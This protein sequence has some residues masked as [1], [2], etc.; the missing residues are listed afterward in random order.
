MICSKFLQIS[1]LIQ[2]WHG[3]SK[4][5]KS[6]FV[7][8]IEMIICSELTIYFKML[9]KGCWGEHDIKYVKN[10]CFLWW[11]FLSV[12]LTLIEY[13]QAVLLFKVNYTNI[14]SSFQVGLSITYYPFPKL[15]VLQFYNF[16]EHVK[17]ITDMRSSSACFE[18]G[19]D[20]KIHNIHLSIFLFTLHQMVSQASI[21][22]I[23]SSQLTKVG[24]QPLKSH[25]SFTWHT[26]HLISHSWT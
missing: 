7:N 14:C 11:Q 10:K 16:T 13:D 21:V 4:N 25:Q 22:P 20:S 5:V 9:Q 8:M 3:S 12:T 23:S 1:R 19:C 17:C 2:I 18:S 15:K 26:Y 24:N 6:G